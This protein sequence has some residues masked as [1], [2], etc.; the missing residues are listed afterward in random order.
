MASEPTSATHPDAAGALTVPRA[1]AILWDCAWQAVVLALLARLLGGIA[2]GIVGGIWQDMAPSAPPGFIGRPLLEEEPSGSFSWAFVRQHGFVML[3]GLFFLLKGAGRFAVYSRA[4]HHRQAAVWA[5]GLLAR[6]TERWFDLI[7]GNAFGAMVAAIVLQV[8]QQ[9]S[10]TQ[11]VWQLCMS[12]LQPLVQGVGN[13]LPHSGLLERLDA[14]CGWYSENRLK[15][16]F[17]FFYTAAICDDLGLPNFKTLGR[18]AWRQLHRRTG[19][20]AIRTEP[21]SRQPERCDP[22]H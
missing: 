19:H 5:Q 1:A 21:P 18:Y 7:V 20:A 22:I 13:L 2:V 10:L 16:M 11:F 8:T 12:F 9:F 17:W 15:F 6:A 14:W 4:E 3:A